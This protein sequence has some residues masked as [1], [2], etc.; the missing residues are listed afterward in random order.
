MESLYQA[1]RK[2]SSKFGP[3]EVRDMNDRAVL[4]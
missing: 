2:Q 1:A 4:R 3:Y